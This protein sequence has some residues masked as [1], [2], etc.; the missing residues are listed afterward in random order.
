MSSFE[1]FVGCSSSFEFGKV[2]V[3]EQ[4]KG[5]GPLKLMFF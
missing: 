2:R 4:S 1:L 5:G 3:I